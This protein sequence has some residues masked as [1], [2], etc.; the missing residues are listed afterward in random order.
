MVTRKHPVVAVTGASGAGTTVVQ[1]AFGEIFQK[2]GLNAAFVEGDS[3][4]RYEPD[5]M[6]RVVAEA[7]QEDKVLSCY[8]PELN[9]FSALEHLFRRYSETGTG[10]VRH[11]VTPENQHLYPDVSDAFTP[12]KDITENT[13]LL[14]YEGLHGGVVA[15]SWTRRRMSESTNPVVVERRRQGVKGGVDVAQYVDLLIGVVPAIN[16][17][18]IQR[19]HHDRQCFDETPEQVTHDIIARLRDYIH[20]IVPQFSLTDI[21]FQRMPVVDTS[22][23]FIADMVP[24]ET[25]SVMVVRFREPKKY[26]FPLFLRRIDGAFMSR[27]NTMVIPGGE[28]RHALSVICSPL[29]ERCCE[30]LETGYAD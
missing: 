19:I 12:W 4:L 10:R 14:F 9:D 13:D 25:E 1:R 30:N 5:E 7:A 16:L 26:D 22:N 27:A 2:R 24:T 21:N 15:S 11:R 8:G 3:F 20:F 28:F 23:P 18:W 17:E 29:I 6:C